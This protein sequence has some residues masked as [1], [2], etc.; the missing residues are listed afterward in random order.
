M[1][2]RAKNIP[3]SG[4]IRQ[5]YTRKIAQELDDESTF[6]VSNRYN[7]KDLAGEDRKSAMPLNLNKNYIF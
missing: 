5:T 7:I 4:P 1:S 3:M 6:K 2:Q